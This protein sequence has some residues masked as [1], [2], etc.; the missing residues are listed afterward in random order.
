M[1]ADIATPAAAHAQNPDRP[2]SMGFTHEPDSE[3]PLLL[4]ACP[5][6]PYPR[7]GALG[8]QHLDAW[9][10]REI[11][12]MTPRPAAPAPA[13]YLPSVRLNLLAHGALLS[14]A[15]RAWHAIPASPP[16]T[17][18]GVLLRRCRMTVCFTG[19]EAT[20]PA[21]LPTLRAALTDGNALTGEITVRWFPG[22]WRTEASP[23]LP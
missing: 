15:G 9:Y 4:A 21:N 1:N 13:P 20:A 11:L 5:A 6:D 14:V 3:E 12:G 17:W 16:R 18:P 22:V 2:W 7:R 19:S 23:W 10:C 8:L